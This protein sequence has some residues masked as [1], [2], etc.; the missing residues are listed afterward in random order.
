MAPGDI[1]EVQADTPGGSKT[2]NEM[3][4]WGT[5][6]VGDVSNQVTLRGRSGDTVTIDGQSTRAYAITQ[7]TTGLDYITISNLTVSGGTTRN[8]FLEGVGAVADNGIILSNIISTGGAGG[9]W[10]RNKS[11]SSFSNITVSGMSGTTGFWVTQNG[12]LTNTAVTLSNISV[13]GGGTSGAGGIS[14]SSVQDL[15]I[16]GN[17][18][19]SNTAASGVGI[20]LR[21]LSGTTTLSSGATITTN[22]TNYW[23]LW[24]DSHTGGLA[25]DGSVDIN[26]TTAQ[27]GFYIN[28]SILATGS[29]INKIDVNAAASGGIRIDG[30]SNLEF[31]QVIATNNTNNGVNIEGASSGIVFNSTNGQS[32]VSG[33]T[34]DGVSNNG[35]S[36]ILVENFIIKNNGGGNGVPL[37]E[38][39][40]ITGHNT[41]VTVARH[42]LIY[43]ND[44]TCFAFIGD[45]SLTAYNNACLSNGVSGGPRGSI[46]TDNDSGVLTLKNNIVSEGLLYEIFSF[47]TTALSTLTENYNHFY[48]PSN[49]NFSTTDGGVAT[50][51]SL[52]AWQT[53]SS[54][55][56][57]SN[58]S[59]P[60]FIST[61][62]PNFQLQPLSPAIDSGTNVSL[63]ADFL[64]NPIYGTPDIGAYEY[65]PPYTLGTHDVDITGGVRL[66]KNGKYRYTTATTS[67]A[68]ATLNV[69]PVGGFLS[70]DYSEFLN[71]SISQWST[72]GD[73][74]KT[75]TET[76]TTATSTV[77]TIGDL[78][79]NTHYTV[80]VD[81]TQYVAAQ[82][83]SSGEISFTYTGGYST[84]TFGV[85][86]DATGPLAF[87]PSSPANGANVGSTQTFT[88]N[89]T[90]DPSAGLAKYQLYVDGALNQ[91]N[92]TGTSFSPATSFSCGNHPWYVRAV[93]N[94]GNGTNSDT[95]TFS[96]AC[97]GGP[98]FT[99]PASS[100]PGYVAPRMQTI[101]DGKVTYLDEVVS[102]T[103]QVSTTPT[104]KEKSTTTIPH[105]FTR[106][107]KRGSQGSDVRKLQ[108]F[109]KKDPTT[110][111][112]GLVTGYY[113]ALTE[114]AVQRFQK[115]Y[116]IASVGI[117]GYGTV[118][119]K[120]RAKLNALMSE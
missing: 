102:T 93:D 55:D 120:T 30:V 81:G 66:Y 19:V 75:W 47:D 65:Q 8:L 36:S 109:L 80:N 28:N 45:S 70:S 68:T 116:N 86:P 90:T 23:G 105:L 15:T 35:S 37:N 16:S 12:T 99:G 114:Q 52:T 10:V 43:D 57:N 27:A 108:E 38:G 21:S 101:T 32:E 20:S 29:H 87:S 49:S 92:I 88:W 26:T 39:D 106:P 83:N 7:Q 111:P 100:L 41:S 98:L 107:L 85:S 4:T 5:N 2:Y 60:L 42:N 72:S 13:T 77:H 115:K 22:S 11:N 24:I 78:A 119:P 94:A 14:V 104:V 59:N 91:D 73:Y 9:I 63:T 40:G 3:V 50:Q 67:T 113:G 34:H 44:N 74:A 56:L 79:A 69:T 95:Y 71:M 33:N 48:H 62:T 1:V 53:A 118:G 112:E 31:K 58:E 110:Y 25:F 61:T 54:Q 51:A 76:S 97:G 84:H 17:L 117:P 18:T 6:D 64:G 82:S 46:W 96:V 89:A 103:V